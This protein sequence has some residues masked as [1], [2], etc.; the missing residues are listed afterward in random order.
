RASSRARTIA[1]S[2]AA[3][4]APSMVHLPGLARGRT[5]G[6]AGR[7]GSPRHPVL[8]PIRTLTVGPG[9]PPGQPDALTLARRTA[10]S[11]TVT[12]G[13]ELHRPRSTCV[14]PRQSATRG[15][16]HRRRAPPPGWARRPV[17]G[18]SVRVR[19]AREGAQLLD[20]RGRVLGPVHRRA[21]DEDVCAGVRRPLDRRG[22]DTAVDLDPHVEV[23]LGDRLPRAADL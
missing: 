23:A 6:C 1:R 10:G 8:P 9:V 20:A 14:L 21:G 15:A 3:V 2:S 22:R 13:S 4:I 16:G 19:G 7:R 18:A 17:T 12:A 5:H 11:R